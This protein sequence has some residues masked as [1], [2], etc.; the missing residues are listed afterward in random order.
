MDGDHSEVGDARFKVNGN[1]CKVEGD[2]FKAGGAHFKMD[3]EH[4]ELDGGRFELGGDHLKMDDDHS[5][6]DHFKVGEPL[7]ADG[8]QLN[9]AMTTL[10]CTVV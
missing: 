9:W 4:F 8:D 6:V 1:H 3:G 7:K 5:E 2:H 10:K